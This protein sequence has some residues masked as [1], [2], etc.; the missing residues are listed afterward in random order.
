MLKRSSRVL[1]STVLLLVIGLVSLQSQTNELL[2]F[3]TSGTGRSDSLGNKVAIEPRLSTN[4]VAAGSSARVVLVLKIADGWHVNAHIPT[5]D[6]LVGT[7]VQMEPHEGVIISDIRYPKSKT[8]KFE[9]ADNPLEVYEGNIHIF[10]ALQV[11]EKLQPGIQTL[12]GLLEYQACDNHVCLP[13]AKLEFSIPIEIV[14]ATT[15]TQTVNEE[16]F[17]GYSEAAPASESTNELA[18]LLESQGTLATF[19][20]IFLIGL[21]LNLTPCVYPMLSVTVSLFGAQKETKFGVVFGKAIV[22]VLGIASMYSVLGVAAALGGGLFGSWLQSPWVLATI[23]ALLFGL[24]LSMFGLFQLQMPYWLTSRLGGTTGTGIIS[25]YVSGLVVGVFAA[26]CVGPPVIALL[27]MVGAKGDPVFGFWVF[28]TLSLGLGL[29]YLILGTFSGL[30]KKIPRSGPWMIWVER[31]FGVVLIGAALFY[32]SLAVLPKFTAWVIPIVLLGGGIYLGFIER[33]GR[34]RKGLQRVQWVF[35]VA[36]I[37]MGLLAANNLREPGIK[38]EKYSLERLAEAR[39]QNQPVMIDF[40]ADWCIPCLELDRRTF[41]DQAIIEATD[42]MV[43]LKVDLTRFDSPES[44]A[45]RKQYNIAGVPTIVF[46][47]RDGGEETSARVI[48]FLPPDRFIE[49]VRIVTQ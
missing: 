9:F 37:T 3:Q 21:A 36:V 16:I 40:Y 42:G 46:L 11:S 2:Q 34:A 23:A 22:Y 48:G 18:N 1:L 43:R 8:L 32:L 19:L 29:P 4:K 26:P 41:T 28:F 12:K 33:S 25:L 5:E 6:Y 45:L 49:S 14:T 44:E 31:I 38:W 27:A 7:S 47:R 24:A 15:P 20:A 10:L 39:Q 35:G 30:L 13:P 17:S